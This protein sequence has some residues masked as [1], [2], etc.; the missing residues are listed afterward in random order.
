[1]APEQ[2][3]RTPCAA[4]DQYSLGVV[5]Y[6]LLSGQRPFDHKDPRT[7]VYHLKYSPPPVLRSLDATIPQDLEAICLTTL[8]KKPGDRYP[9]CQDLADDL[10]RWQ[11]GEP[12]KVRTLGV[13]EKLL[14]W[15][16]RD[17]RLALSLLATLLCLITAT[18][19]SSFS[20]R[21]EAQARLEA[22]NAQVKATDALNFAQTALISEVESKKVAVKKAEE[23]DLA[24]RSEKDA[25]EQT[26]QALSL[27][28]GAEKK[29]RQARQR[30]EEERKIAQR[31]LYYRLSTAAEREIRD[32]NLTRARELI[33]QCQQP[34]L[35]HLLGWEWHYL[36]HR[37][38]Q[39]SSRV[40]AQ[41]SDL[42]RLAFGT[43]IINGLPILAMAR[44]NTVV[45][46]RRNLNEKRRTEELLNP[47][48]RSILSCVA[49]GS[50]GEPL[51][52][53]AGDESGHVLVWNLK[54]I[55][56][57]PLRHL[58]HK[59]AV[60]CVAFSPDNKQLASG[61]D[62]GQ[63]R[64]WN[65]DNDKLK[66]DRTVGRHHAP[67]R[68]VA[69]SPAKG[70]FD[71]KPPKH[72]ASML[73]SACQDNEVRL[74]V[75]GTGEGKDE[76]LPGYTMGAFS[77][78]GTRFAL[79]NE[80]G[81]V[82]LIR[83]DQRDQRIPLF[84]GQTG[85]VQKAEF[86]GGSQRLAALIGNTVMVW[87]LEGAPPQA[88]ILL[89]VFDVRTFSL[90]HDG[91]F[92]AVL[93]RDGVVHIWHLE[94][95][96]VRPLEF[97]DLDRMDLTEDGG[98]PYLA[99][100]HEHVLSLAFS[101]DGQRLASAG[102]VAK[103]GK[104]EGQVVLWEVDPACK[105][106]RFPNDPGRIFAV[107]FSPDGR[108]LAEAHENGQIRLR[109]ATQPL[110]WPAAKVMHHGTGDIASVHRHKCLEGV[111]H[112]MRG[113]IWQWLGKADPTGKQA[114]WHVAFSPDSK[115]LASGSADGQ[116]RVWDLG[117]RAL[118]RPPIPAFARGVDCVAFAP[119]GD[120]LVASSREGPAIKVWKAPHTEEHVESFE[121]QGQSGNV[122]KIAFSPDGKYLASAGDDGMV[123]LWDV[124]TRKQVRALSGHTR[125]VVG[126]AFSPDGQRLASSG[127]DMTVRI[128]DPSSG[129][130]TL[131]LKGD[132]RFTS[133]LAF[134]PDG[135]QLVASSVNGVKVWNAPFPKE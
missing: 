131:V 17:P 108:L 56:D 123:R 63:V 9:S 34:D 20:Y 85:E 1:M 16:R 110:L 31:A 5:L 118:L 57:P 105:E 28:R 66:P 30:E 18:L 37:C 15:T 35:K 38:P 72:L 61:G 55:K 6:E 101:P 65:L 82:S 49:F 59:G 12:V 54:R 71:A 86:G 125:R 112:F 127:L 113:A 25:H 19:F 84:E 53:A 129:Q 51:L 76:Y 44:R 40:E 24:K 115:Y 60:R 124:A 2:L 11:E 89:P 58:G 14:Y 91:K 98:K 3:D 27:A 75:L 135:R 68:L 13:V 48:G 80:K 46:W 121:Q 52:L 87:A 36:N 97:F 104:V 7:W 83:Y 78:D 132:T 29:E 95:G 8:A 23:A 32:G 96:R 106:S 117:T 39:L 88:S 134:S 107:A 67:I 126:V 133:G 109:D 45:L 77:P 116:V 94:K 70:A 100:Y 21:R 99:A 102:A 41:V 26:Q 42:H 114:A 79:A 10:R 22:D 93:G 43:E 62:D 119:V 92:L 69:F 50:G 4:S 73:C 47:D 33:E 90:S 64:L 111:A 128:W 120:L 130:E 81:T 103:E 74:W 122:N